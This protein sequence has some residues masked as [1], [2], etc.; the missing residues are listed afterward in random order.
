MALGGIPR[1]QFFEGIKIAHARERLLQKIEVKQGEKFQE[2]NVGG[3]DVFWPLSEDYR[4]VADI[5]CECLL[6]FHPHCYIR[7]NTLV[8]EGDIVF[9]CGAC[10][11]LFG[12]HAVKTAKKVY[13]FEPL[14]LMADCLSETF[15][16]EILEERAEV[17]PIALGNFEGNI[18]FLQGDSS[19][20][21][22]CTISGN[23]WP[24]VKITT[25]DKFVQANEIER[26]DYIKSDVEGGE[27]ELILGAKEVIGR[28]KPKMA[29]TTYHYPDDA[30]IILKEVM[31][32]RP[33]YKYEF[34]GQ[35]EFIEGL[36]PVMVH[37]W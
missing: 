30:E 16:K 19:V 7:C 6:P 12:K 20:T 17:V 28:F 10:E 27:R 22:G 34:V 31:E 9:D 26:V 25:I 1:Y 4:R 13:L 24:Q 18:Q 32:I 23:S 33:D 37:F 29:I 3:I 5:Y 2:V 11:G 15:C 36:F 8:D 35:V 21:D 14:Q